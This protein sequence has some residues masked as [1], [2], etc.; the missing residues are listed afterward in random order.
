MNLAYPKHLRILAIAP[1]TRGFGFAILD[2][3]ETLV[4]WGVKSVRQEKN[5]RCLA[6]V[7]KLITHYEPEIIVL[8]DHSTKNCRRSPRIRALS[9]QIIDLASSR[10]VGV[11]LFSQE[12]VRRIFFANGQ[13]TKY[14]LAKIIAVRFPEELGARLP[15]KRLPWMSEDYRMDIF[16][17]VAL[18]LVFRHKKRKS[19]QLLN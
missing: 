19:K 10:N 7:E 12:Q 8:Q 5:T 14:A 18:V 13:G 4:D 6:K 17:A 3:G 2:G 16:D 15:P 9:Q 1:S 11:A